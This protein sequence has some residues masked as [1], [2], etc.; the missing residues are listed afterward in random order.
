MIEFLKWLIPVPPEPEPV[1]VP[2]TPKYPDFVTKLLAGH[3]E[4]RA[5]NGLKPLVLSKKLCQ[6]AQLHS[7]WM[8][9]NGLWHTGFPK[10]LT[11]LYYNYSNCGE[12]IAW[13]YKT[14]EDCTNAWIRSLGHRANILGKFTEVGFGYADAYW[15]ADYATPSNSTDDNLAVTLWEESVFGS[16][17]SVT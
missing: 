4:Y 12:N 13:N 10:R 8:T 9:T 6:V 16:S 17:V 5:K 14:P 11:K 1:P 3:N 7:D 2:P 15:C